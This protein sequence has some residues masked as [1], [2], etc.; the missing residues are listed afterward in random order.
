MDL[1][2]YFRVMWRFRWLMGVGF[3]IGLALAFLAMA[4][5]HP[6]GQPAVSYRTD[7]KWVSYSTLFVTQGGFPWG[8][9]TLNIAGDQSAQAQKRG[10]QTFAN[11]D[12]FSN[13][14]VLY[15]NLATS[16]PVRELMLRDGPIN[17][18]LEAAP[19]TM[20]QGWGVTLPLISIAAIANEP[21]RSV[22]LNK[23]ATKAFMDFLARQ[24]S[25]NGIPQKDRVLVTIVKRAD[26]AK[27]LKG[28]S[29]TVAIVAF[30]LAMFLF[31]GFALILENLRPRYRLVSAE[32]AAR[33]P[34]AAVPGASPAA[35]DSA[36]RSA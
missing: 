16:D 3:V 1:R 35:A 10:G 24:Q 18:E 27:L 26:Q 29:Y 4:R 19:V 15:S 11:P 6:G 33:T 34:V 28:R 14:A 23:R 7:Q 30:L 8:R 9:S 31:T 32:E 2:L 36:R 5:V 17:G 13:L 22:A 25:T 12:R 20:D 21:A